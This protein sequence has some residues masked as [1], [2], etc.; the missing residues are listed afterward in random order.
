MSRPGRIRAGYF[1]LARVGV[2]GLQMT[3][4]LCCSEAFPIW[5]PIFV[6]LTVSILTEHVGVRELRQL[7]GMRGK[8]LDD[9]VEGP[10]FI[11]NFAPFSIWIRG[12]RKFGHTAIVYAHIQ[13]VVPT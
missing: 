6:K 13:T 4:L 5:Q 12:L 3:R 1:L 10:P 9:W 2:Q 8:S 7:G 11:S